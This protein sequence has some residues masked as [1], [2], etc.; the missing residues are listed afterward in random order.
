MHDAKIH[1]S[2]T[3]AALSCQPPATSHRRRSDAATKGSPKKTPRT[4]T[5]KLA[6]A[7]APL[8]MGL[9][10]I[11]LAQS[12]A[13]VNTGSLN[14]ARD[15]HTATLLPNGKV[16]VAGSNGAS[17]WLASAE[18]YDVGLG[19]NASWQPQIT[20]VTSPLC[21]GASLALTGSQFRGVSE[22]SGGNNCQ[23][24]PADYPVVQL[25]SLGNDQILFPL[26]ASWSSNSFRSLPVTGLPIGYALVTVFVNGI[27]S[28]SSIINIVPAQPELTLIPYG[29]SVILT[30]QTDAF[31]FALEFATDLVPG[32][33][34]NP[35][36]PGPVVFG[37]QFV[38]FEPV[39]GLR[40][41]Y[42]L[43]WGQ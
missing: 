36:S 15:G 8:V 18:L 9:P 16:L 13:W 12:D 33:A 28:P 31:G 20:S 22:G 35:V 11:V 42:R 25:R 21:S 43:K 7:V 23:N 14:T 27:P 4:S 17:G 24:S 32:A 2:F 37:D 34:W 3:R 1:S 41:F 40:K 26:A 6:L 29:A 10:V 30:W 5:V 39:A 19:F 38:V